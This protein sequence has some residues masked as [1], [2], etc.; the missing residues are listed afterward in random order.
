MLSARS[1]RLT[2]HL[3][4][5][6]GARLVQA[7]LFEDRGTSAQCHFRRI[8]SSTHA[9]FSS[10]T[11]AQRAGDYIKRADAVRRSTSLSRAISYLVSTARLIDLFCLEVIN[12]ETLVHLPTK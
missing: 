7:G 4:N 9:T 5:K 8:L 10:T 11:K 12:F 3:N 1:H 6:T 2:K